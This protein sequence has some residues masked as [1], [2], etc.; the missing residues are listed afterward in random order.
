MGI[1]IDGRVDSP[2]ERRDGGRM[3]AVDLKLYGTGC[4][5]L[6]RML[7]Q[8]WWDPER[9]RVLQ[10]RRLQAILRHAYARSDFYQARFDRVG[11]HPDMLR[12]QD[13]LRQLPIL[14]REDL[15]DS[16]GL[17][18]RRV[19]PADLVTATTSGSTGRRTTVYFDRQSAFL[20]KVLLKARARLTCGL[21]P[22]HRVALFQE[23]PYA[24][25]TAER[26]RIRSFSI[27]APVA[28]LL[29]AVRRF[30]PDAVY[31]FPGHL[32]LLGEAAAGALRPRFVFTSGELL[33]G[34]LRR[35]LEQAFAAPVLDIYGCTE[36]KEIAFQCPEGGGYHLNADWLHLEALGP[37]DAS[38]MPEGTLVVTNLANFGM[39]LI[40]YA[41]GD[42]GEVLDERCPCGRGLP[43]VRPT[44]GRLVDYFVLAGGQRVAPYSMTCAIEG[45]PG[46]RQYQIA[47]T[48]GN[49][50]LV[51]VVPLDDFDAAAE[52]AVP[53]LL[54]PV[55]P[56]VTVSVE[57]V[58]QLA[59][60]RS[61]KYRIVRT[62][63]APAS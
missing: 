32:A 33:D 39:P 12:T 31:G 30:A 61:G 41:M 25:R 2:H 48:A 17:I 6:A 55:L 1:G 20:G 60:E 38:G 3:K 63:L 11:L 56:G 29:P 27:H 9:L 24:G 8:Q 13:D 45:V 46:M 52:A 50:V 58:E 36:V 26:G 53:R 44:S 54:G 4:F 51:R 23:E 15:R 40:R 43:L 57:R 18:D 47:Q 10:W 22:W 5:Q 49:R 19:D 37:E 35:R 28:E 34:A 14:T 62:E 59:A 7:R 16:R 42:A 21:R